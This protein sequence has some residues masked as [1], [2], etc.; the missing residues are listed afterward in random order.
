MNSNA[1]KED[2]GYDCSEIAQDFMDA[3]NGKG[4][5]YRI[6]GKDGFINGYE[7]NSILEFDYHEVYSDGK[8][9]YDP[10]YSNVPIEKGDYFRALKK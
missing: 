9:I 4:K 1:Y 2:F 3:A 6:D 10:R 5:I 7:Y 8:F